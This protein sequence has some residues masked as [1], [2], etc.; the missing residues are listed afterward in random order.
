MLET[1]NLIQSYFNQSPDGILLFKNDDLIIANQPAQQLLEAFKINADYLLQI[2]KNAW[3]QQRHDDCANCAIKLS[4]QAATVPITFHSVNSTAHYSLIYKPLNLQRG[5]FSVTLEN[6]EQ[7][8]R[9][10]QV[11]QQRTLNQYINEAHEKER[12]K[13]SQDLHDSIAQGIYSTLMGINRLSNR[14]DLSEA[15]VHQLGMNLEK[16]LRNILSE[17]KGMALDIRPSVLDSFGLVPA[18]KALAARTQANT[19]VKINVIATTDVNLAANIQNILYRI[20]QESINNAIKHADP[21]EINVILTKH[22]SYFQ[23]E[24]LD[25]GRGFDTNKART[26][27]GHSLGLMNMN[28]RVKSFNGAFTIKSEI[29]RGTSVKVQFPYNDASKETVS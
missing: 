2:G 1:V 16:Q 20:S 21:S 5:I 24:V 27:N 8:G 11:E 23:L 4:L 28:E 3:E 13:I 19:G 14:H 6:R 15:E 22:H 29:N 18:I 26:F 10:S 12:Q 9:I 17:V 25:N 7:Q